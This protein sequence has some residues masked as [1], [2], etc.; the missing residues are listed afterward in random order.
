MA[1]AGGPGPGAPGG[2][3]GLLVPGDQ[4][5][6]RLVAAMEGVDR[7]V[8]AFVEDI[9]RA[10][11]KVRQEVA[12][13]REASI[14]ELQGAGAA[15][16]QGRA[17]LESDRAALQTE[18]EKQQN[19]LDDAFQELRAEKARLQLLQED[20][21][22]QARELRNAQA[23]KNE[24][25][26]HMAQAAMYH[27]P[28]SMTMAATPLGAVGATPLP[29]G[30]LGAAGQ[31]LHNGPAHSS[32][33]GTGAE[34]VPSE[35]LGPNAEYL[36]A[37]GGLEKANSPLH[38]WEVWAKDS[39]AWRPLPTMSVRR[40]YCAV[41]GVRRGEAIYALGGN[42][43]HNVMASCEEYNT[44]SGKWRPVADM[45][46]DRMWHSAVTM[47]DNVLVVGGY[48][49]SD[50]LSSV[51][52]FDPQGDSETDATLGKWAPLAN[53]PTARSTCG[54]TSLNG[55]VY[56]VGGFCAPR[57]MSVVEAYDPRANSWWGVSPL[58]EPRRDL[59]V[60]AVDSLNLVVAVGG[61]NGA[62]VMGNVDGF[63]PRANKW[64]RMGAIGTP[65]QLLAV[66][67]IGEV[68]YAIGGF[69]GVATSSMVEFLDMRMNRG[70]EMPS[71]LTPRLGLGI[72]TVGQ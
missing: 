2:G 36:Y 41:A 8:G 28:M 25:E 63:D 15:L 16:A 60:C 6:A 72:V 58:L 70:G 13:E 45:S 68:L 7:V 27:A 3:A 14:A 1:G 19:K 20:V 56:A 51:E 69:D 53:M 67:S 4:A 18:V 71:L 17:Q 10:V 35:P 61:Y 65:R 12:G 21:E 48:D 32:G 29:G 52:L 62:E 31:R 50:Y 39:G 54:V 11:A 23:M 66:S 43:G 37:V 57:Y 46:T 26:R 42:D 34:G 64:Q 33:Q 38:T 40:G 49:G 44:L 24:V 5:G 59:G 55:T 22:R 9:G 30:P 47:G